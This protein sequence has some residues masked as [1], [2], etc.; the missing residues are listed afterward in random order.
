L[1]AQLYIIVKLEVF[2]AWNTKRLPATGIL[3]GSFFISKAGARFA[4][5]AVAAALF[6]V[7]FVDAARNYLKKDKVRDSNYLFRSCLMMLLTI[8]V[9]AWVLIKG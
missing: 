2:C 1:S 7:N 9:F 8:G 5:I 4:L 6:M 3:A